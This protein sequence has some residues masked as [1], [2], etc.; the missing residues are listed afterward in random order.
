MTAQ[1]MKY[2]LMLLWVAALVAG[3]PAAAEQDSRQK[4]PE[5]WFVTESAP[6]L[7]EAGLDTESPCEGGRSAWLRSLSETPAGYGTFMQSF[8]AKAF[9]DKRLRFSAVVRTEDVQGWAGLWMRV[10]GQDAKEPLAFD[11]MQSRALVGTTPC[12]RYEVVLDVPSEARSIMAGLLLSGTGKAWIGSVRFEPVE[13]SVPV[14][15]LLPSPKEGSEEGSERTAQRGTVPTGRINNVWFNETQVEGPGYRAIQESDGTWKDN[16]FGTLSVKGNTVKGVYKQLPLE[17]LVTATGSSTRIEGTW[18]NESVRIEMDPKKLTMKYG[19]FERELTSE[20]KRP[21]Y[22]RTCVRYGRGNG[23]S[24]SDQID[25]C[26]KAVARQ[27]PPLQLVVAFLQNGF[28][29]RW[30][31]TTS[32]PVPRMGPARQPKAMD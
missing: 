4:L 15:N 28:R 24:R 21:D 11:N 29:Q 14:T 13:T 25:V 16:L 26:G 12:K 18:G 2:G 17:L 27:P 7:Y 22:D 3:P 30:A 31:P 19:V 6:Q 10:E 9:H 32:P 1:K 8:G 5:G 20:D 23:L